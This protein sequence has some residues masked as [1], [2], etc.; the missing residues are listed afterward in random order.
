M[1]SRHCFNTVLVRVSVACIP[2][3]VLI[4]H[5]TRDVRQPSKI[6]CKHESTHS[7][8]ITSVQ[9]NPSA[10]TPETILSASTDGLLCLSNAREADEDE[11]VLEVGNLE[12]SVSRC[13][14]MADS[15]IWSA[16]DMETFSTWHQSVSLLRVA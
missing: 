1:Q 14:W 10:S 12:K 9:F 13:G 11:A 3:V 8:D 6:L 5:N 15:G 4:I 16:T 7:D 2:P